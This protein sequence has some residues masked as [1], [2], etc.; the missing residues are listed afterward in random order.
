MA[1]SL[2][3]MVESTVKA[4]V[5]EERK[6]EQL[7]FAPATEG[8]VVASIDAAKAQQFDAIL[9]LGGGVPLAPRK[10]LP[11]VAARCQAARRSGA[12]PRRS[13]RFSASRRARR[14]APSCSDARGPVVFEGRRRPRSHRRGSRR[15]GR[16][17]ETTSFDTIKALFARTHHA[18]WRAGNGRN[19][20]RVPHGRSG[21]SSTGLRRHPT[22]GFELT[23]LATPDAALTATRRRARGTRN[24][25][26]HNA[27]KLAP[28]YTTLSG[29]QLVTAPP[30]RRPG[31]RGPRE[32]A[33]EHASDALL[34]ASYGG[35]ARADGAWRAMCRVRPRSRGVGGDARASEQGPSSRA[36]GTSGSARHIA[37]RRRRRDGAPRRRVA[38]GRKEPPV[39]GQRPRERPAQAGEL[40]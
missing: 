40:C 15:A 16:L 1:T 24:E 28:T 26:S 13:R 10:Q 29:V 21:R 14:T 5:D 30:L 37:G 11:F 39:L 8:T 34:L 17:V 20:E 9:V 36:N 7:L 12:R 31:P 22:R 25:V 32:P 23:L 4:A 18:R 19:Y 2:Q 6:L 3:H 33:A 38:L 27:A 35:A